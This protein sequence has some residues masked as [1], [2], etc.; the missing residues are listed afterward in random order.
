MVS[1]VRIFLF[2]ISDVRFRKLVLL[3][4]QYPLL[5]KMKIPG[6][7]LLLISCTIL[8]ARAQEQRFKV[9]GRADSLW[10]S[11]LLNKANKQ[12]APDSARAEPRWVA[13]KVLYSPDRRLRIGQLISRRDG[14]TDDVLTPGIQYIV[15]NNVTNMQ[16]PIDTTNYD[17]RDYP[18]TEIYAINPFDGTYLILSGFTKRR[19]IGDD[20]SE[21]RSS[22]L[23]NKRYLVATT[24]RTNKDSLEQ[25]PIEIEDANVDDGAPDIISGSSLYLAAY[26]KQDKKKALPYLRYDA[27]K[28]EVQFLTTACGP[29]DD[30]EREG[31]DLPF[32]YVY[33]GTFRYVNKA[34][35]LV[36]NSSYYSPELQSFDN[37]VRTKKYK[38]GPSVIKATLTE[39]YEEIGMGVLRVNYVNYFVNGQTISYKDQMNDLIESSTNIRPEA[40][41]QKDGKLIFLVTDVTTPNRMG[42]CGSC[43]FD[44]SAF[45]LIGSKTKRKLFSF[46]S[47]SSN[48]YVMYR[49]NDGVK[50][51]EGRF[52]LRSVNGEDE[53]EKAAMVTNQYWKNNSTYVVKVSDDNYYREFYINFVTPGRKTYTR[54]TMGR[55]LREP[56]KSTKIQ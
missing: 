53:E 37:V 52:Y 29:Y 32:L 2:R 49:Y 31:C 3:Y 21:S 15:A 19:T 27:K 4:F 41:P 28:M 17:F 43:E 35:K 1:K 44:D 5:F 51:R 54:L 10:I 36:N 26:F 20:I 40:K 33:Q 46:D 6:F 22:A 47:S 24:V 13:G 12:Y 7:L 14:E 39:K 25:V 48:S 56:K 55:L 23:Y 16:L 42:A 8:T 30:D 11:E 50:I 34:F 18:I 9:D 45:W 38:V